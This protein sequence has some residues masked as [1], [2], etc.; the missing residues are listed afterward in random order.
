VAQA[1][2]PGPVGAELVRRGRQIAAETPGHDF[3]RGLA[4]G[5]LPREVFLSYLVQNAL[6]LTGYAAALRGALE[7]GVPPSLAGLLTEIETAISGPAI[8]GHVTEYRSRAGR[9]PDL[10]AATPSPVTTAYVGHL[11]A[12]ARSGGAATL[13]A[14]LPGEQSYAAAGR[15]YA[16]SGDLTPR[17]PYA[18]WIAQYT[19]GQVDELVTAILAAIASTAPAGRNSQELLGVYEISARLDGQFWEM[20]SQPENG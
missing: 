8:D 19:A 10:Q 2:A 1:P 17:N 13:A 7:A 11:R 5:S 18:G 6:F 20:A 3:V 9:I 16:A 14:I 4:D 15:Y 12:S